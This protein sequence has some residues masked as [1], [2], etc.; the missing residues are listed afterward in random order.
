MMRSRHC[1][2]LETRTMNAGE[3][4]QQAQAS[5]TTSQKIGVDSTADNNKLLG[6]EML[7]FVSAVA[8]LVFHYQHFVFRGVA[9]PADFDRAH[10]PLYSFLVLL[11]VHGFEG[12][13]V[14]WCIS[15]FIFFWRYR[16]SISDGR[17]GGRKF[18]VLRF[19]RLY[20]LHFA[21]LLLVAFLQFIYNRSNGT[22]FVY[23]YNDLR[24]FVLQLFMASNWGLQKGDSFNGPIWSISLEVL[25]YGVFYLV[26]AFISRSW[27]VN[28][29]VLAFCGVARVLGVHYPI[30]D[31]LAF[32][33]M[34]GLSAIAYRSITSPRMRSVSNGAALFS[35]GAVL[36]VVWAF[37]LYE[38]A[39]F[40]FVFLVCYTPLLLFCLCADF[41]VG[42][43]ARSWI[44]AAGNMTYASY[45]LH[46]PLQLALV[47]VYAGVGA[48]LPFYSAGFFC[49]FIGGT[50]LASYFVYKYLELPAQRT[51]RSRLR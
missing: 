10:Q 42:P 29:I 20:P 24:H 13:R 43:V 49:L 5:A 19:S 44:E 18:F 9:Q 28:V 6:L 39:G 41:K 50:L 37:A 23:P 40:S 16:D 30:F 7:R 31:C 15:G 11:Y 45:L 8:V 33:Y 1:P 38:R 27:L 26:L 46:F 47:I 32:F 22:F 12:V 14:F 34:G 35:A 36:L 21:T 25:V 51:L 2:P 3:T 17:V 48:S 4:E